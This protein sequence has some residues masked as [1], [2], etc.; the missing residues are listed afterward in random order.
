M[1]LTWWNRAKYY[2]QLKEDPEFFKAFNWLQEDLGYKDKSVELNEKYL[3]VDFDD[4]ELIEDLNK[5]GLHIE[6]QKS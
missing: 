4:K 3:Y 1:N 5:W 6:T 2:C